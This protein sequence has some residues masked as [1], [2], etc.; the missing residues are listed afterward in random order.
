MDDKNRVTTHFDR[1]SFIGMSVALPFIPRELLDG[2]PPRPVASFEQYR[3]ILDRYPIEAF[4]HIIVDECQRQQHV[5]PL[6]PEVDVAKLRQESLFD[7]NA[8]SPAGAVGIAQFIPETAQEQYGMKVYVT[9]DYTE[10]VKLRKRFLEENRKVR[11]A[12][13]DN[14]FTLVK[15][16]KRRADKLG[17]QTETRFV[18][19]KID[20]EGQIAGTSLAERAALDQRLDPELSIRN[21]IRYLTE[22]CRA[23]SDRFGG[24]IRHNVLRGLAAYNAGI[25]QVFKFDGMPFLFQTVDYV[26]KIM[27]MYDQMISARK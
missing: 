14:K 1:R 21:G 10:G 27:V 7:P 12:L 15:K 26:R 11:D 19:Y 9:E 13:R 5:F 8:I 18:R 22:V 4:L 20:L 6:E 23:C 17:K 2:A 16:Y 25:D 24:S 3:Y